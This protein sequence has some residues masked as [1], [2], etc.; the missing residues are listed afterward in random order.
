M[1]AMQ[2]LFLKQAPATLQTK[3]CLKSLPIEGN[4]L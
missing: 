4:N 1:R 3:Q 2:A